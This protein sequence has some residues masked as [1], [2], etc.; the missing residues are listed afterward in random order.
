MRMLGTEIKTHSLVLE[1]PQ[2]DSL[3]YRAL[4]LVEADCFGV[5]SGD[6][7]EHPAAGLGRGQGAFR[8]QPVSKQRLGAGGGGL[9]WGGVVS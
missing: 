2:T 7:D 9:C 5:D 8:F 6:R 3:R 4:P 1:R